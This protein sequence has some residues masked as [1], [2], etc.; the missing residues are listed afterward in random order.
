L[1]PFNEFFKKEKLSVPKINE[2][3]NRIKRNLIYYQTN[4]LLIFFIF[5]AYSVL[6][7]PQFLISLISIACLWFYT[8][9][10]REQ[11]LKVGNQEIP[12]KVVTLFLLMVT[13]GMIY[14]SS[15]ASVLWKLAVV[16]SAIIIGH[17]IFFTPEQIDEFGFGVDTPNNVFSAV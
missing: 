7:S 3:P 14:F 1:R 9:K 5:S 11:P 12:E 4:Y 13:V 17:A 10:F 15:A 2:I 8:L 6:T 16:T